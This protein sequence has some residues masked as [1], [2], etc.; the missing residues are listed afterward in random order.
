MK[1]FVNSDAIYWAG[2]DKEKEQILSQTS[3]WHILISYHPKMSNS[4]LD[5]SSTAPG[6]GTTTV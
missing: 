4:Q 6:T 1:N 5:M 3:V 2:D